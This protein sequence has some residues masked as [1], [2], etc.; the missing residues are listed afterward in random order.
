[1]SGDKK[2]I[3]GVVVACILIFAFI[4]YSA[5]KQNEKLSQP[6]FGIT[7]EI[8]GQQHVQRGQVDE[9]QDP[10]TSGD[11][12]GDGV[13]GPGIHEEPVDDGLMVHSMEH[14]AVVLHYDPEKLAENQIN[15]LKDIF[16]KEFK[17]K[18]IMMPRQGMSAPIIM[19][20]WGQILKLN[21]ADQ[22]QMITFMETNND[23]GPEKVSQY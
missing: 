14:G 21:E 5:N 20:S 9:V 6:L 10:P 16:T 13:A 1:M 11:H 15:Q 8:Q 19:T 3:I 23:R 17:G 4:I 22:E 18:K 7:Q 12:Y 2:F